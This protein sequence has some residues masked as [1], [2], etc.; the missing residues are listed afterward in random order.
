[1]IMMMMNKKAPLFSCMS[2]CVPLIVIKW[3]I[4][5]SYKCIERSNGL[6]KSPHGIETNIYFSYPAIRGSCFLKRHFVFGMCRVKGNP[7]FVFHEASSQVTISLQ[8]AIF[9]S[10]WMTE[11]NIFFSMAKANILL[12]T[13]MIVL[14]TLLWKYG[15]YSCI[16]DQLFIFPFLF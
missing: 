3:S 10:D 15:L 5:F 13:I 7:I 11:A 4:E 6:V 2:F 9:S 12:D 8:K 1:M 14:L 16:Y